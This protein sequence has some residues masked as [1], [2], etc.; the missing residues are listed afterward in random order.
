MVF[1]NTEN[2]A[3]RLFQRGLLVCRSLVIFASSPPQNQ[4]RPVL[5]RG[6]AS[7]EIKEHPISAIL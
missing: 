2:I 1:A 6:N 5:S 7:K 4:L 3:R